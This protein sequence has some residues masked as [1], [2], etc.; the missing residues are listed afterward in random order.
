MYSLTECENWRHFAS[1]TERLLSIVTGSCG[2]HLEDG[3]KLTVVA[4]EAG[5]A[6]STAQRWVNLYRRFGLSA[7]ARKRCSDRGQRRELSRKRRD[8]R[9]REL[10]PLRKR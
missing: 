7:L 4:S 10:I 6:Y 3:R 5:V 2:H 9:L 8:M 1:Q